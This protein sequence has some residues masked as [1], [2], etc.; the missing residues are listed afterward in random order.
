M[1]AV[2]REL[3]AG[4]VLIVTTEHRQQF[5]CGY[6]NQGTEIIHPNQHGCQGDGLRLGPPAP[7]LYFWSLRPEGLEPE[8]GLTC[9]R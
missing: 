5:T 7:G 8:V 2:V 9:H 4:D 1:A 3:Q 6:L